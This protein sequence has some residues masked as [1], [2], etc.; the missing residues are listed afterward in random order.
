M[1]R[2]ISDVRNKMKT[3]RQAAEYYCIPKS[4]LHVKLKGKSAF[5]RGGQNAL[6]AQEDKRP[7]ESKKFVNG[8]F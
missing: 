8:G 5:Q 3:L 2:T 4:T 6:S 7:K 1:E